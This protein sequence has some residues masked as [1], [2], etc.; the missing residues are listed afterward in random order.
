M[1]TKIKT[2]RPVFDEFYGRVKTF[3][4]KD[5]S[6]Y[7]VDGKIVRGYRS[8]D[9]T[10]IWLRDHTHQMKGFKHFEKDM[11]SAADMFIAKRQEN[12]S[13][14]DAV[15]Q[16][17]KLFR[18]ANEADV[19]YLLVEAVYTAWQATGDDAWLL[20][21]LG[22]CDA[23]L[24]YSLSDPIR[25]SKEY[26]LV[27]RPFTIDTWDF[28]Y[29]PNGKYRWGGY[30]GI[31]AHTTFGIMH[32]DNTGMCQSMRFL[33][34]M[35]AHLGFADI[36]KYWFERAEAFQRQIVKICWNGKFLTH[37][38]HID[39]ITVEGV[40][41]SR[42][43]SLS[44]AY[45]LNR[46]VLTG[47]QCASVIEEY[48]RRREETRNEY[49]A[50]WYSI[51]PAFPPHSFYYPNKK[52]TTWTKDPGEYV[53][54]GVMPLVG[55]EL[56]RG[57]FENG[58]EEYGLDILHRYYDMIKTTGETYLWYHPDGRPGRSCETTLPT[59][60][61]GSSAMLCALIEGLAGVR[62]E[63]KL[64]EKTRLAPRWSAAGVDQAEVAVGYGASNA[65][66][67]YDY[68]CR[69]ASISIAWRGNASEIQAHVLLPKGMRAAGVE[70]NGA[71]MKFTETAVRSSR[72]AD[73]TLSRR[74]GRVDIQMR[75]V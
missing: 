62:D 8:P 55:G 43:L 12:G 38:V 56:A 33:A 65:G 45:T 57:A 11:R 54:G 60:G 7:P 27:K 25:W 63:H 31:D 50:E 64:Y 5:V 24:C 13:I 16:E 67:S 46:G 71:P 30:S 35:Y 23:A 9:T 66:F 58:F 18:C 19:E 4:E 68:K 53:N 39:P 48:I 29:N 47:E 75:K 44:N 14:Y 37:Q 41:E 51:H 21:S 10:P 28:C 69:D 59:D 42:Q 36:A 26:A 40:D 32:G 2:G 1:Q 15:R 52:R 74:E 3:M 17:G 20:K 49:F 6:E 70:Q 73:F 22:A 72:Y 61:W 34:R